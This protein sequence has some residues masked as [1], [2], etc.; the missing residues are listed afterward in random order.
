MLTVRKV[1]TED[2]DNVIELLEMFDNKDIDREQ[3][4]RLFSP[5]CTKL[6][7]TFFGFAL[8]HEIK[9]VGF[10][11]AIQSQR[12]INGKI[13]KFCNISSWI[14]HPA[15]RKEKKGF[16]LLQ[17]LMEMEGFN[18]YVLSPVKHTF[19]YYINY[20]GFKENTSKVSTVPAL[21]SIRGIFN[22]PNVL[23]N[24]EAIKNYLTETEI[25]LYN[26]H[27]LDNI[28]HILYFYKNK[29]IY[30]IVKP[31]KYSSYVLNSS[32]IIRIFT[33]G[34]F[35]ILKKDFFSSK[36]LLGLVH[37]T[38]NPL[39]FSESLNTVAY[40][41]CKE[42]KIKG[43]SINEKYLIKKPLFL[44]KNHI[45]YSGLYKTDELSQDDF[46]SLYSELTHMNLNHF[47][48]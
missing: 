17:A 43:L 4:K 40:T 11:A 34:W 42:I 22:K 8:V 13:Y 38:N 2:F 14:V 46:D 30:C 28:F 41:I 32:F 48:L 15:Y 33:K 19:N 39:L 16:L 20:Y 1:I 3:W 37:F 26:D 35:K 45:N 9:I 25:E 31:C 36:I 6:N 27:Q 24:H 10:I 23:I 5:V 7:N 29:P 44:I 18:F 47:Q 21:P 12:E